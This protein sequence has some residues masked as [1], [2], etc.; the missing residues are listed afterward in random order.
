[1][2]SSERSLEKEISRAV[3]GV[4]RP[5]LADREEQTPNRIAPSKH[6]LKLYYKHN[7]PGVYD[8]IACKVCDLHSVLMEVLKYFTSCL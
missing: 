6:E 8:R 5:I 3:Q 7:K 2:V 4:V 1:M